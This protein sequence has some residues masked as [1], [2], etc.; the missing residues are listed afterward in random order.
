M[1]E[2]LKPKFLDLKE[3]A[4]VI[5]LAPFVSSLNAR[6]TERNVSLPL[7]ST[8]HVDVCLVIRSMISV[9]SL[10]S[11]NANI[12]PAV[13]RGETV[14]VPIMFTALTVKGT[15]GSAS[16]LRVHVRT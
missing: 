4:I 5:S 14:V 1:N 16:V 10:R 12:I 7:I 3:G 9:P 2:A 13:C 8:T 6:M 11:P 15:L